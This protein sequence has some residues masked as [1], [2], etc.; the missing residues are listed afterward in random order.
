MTIQALLAARAHKVGRA[1]PS[2]L[3][4]HRALSVDPLCIVAW[5]L[6]SEPYS[7][8]AIAIGTK[9]SGFQL[10]V[11]GYPLDRH[12][13]FASL[14]DFAR[15]FC[16]AFEAF[17]RGPTESVEHMGERLL[18]PQRLP[19]IVVANAETIALLGRLGR[20]LA[21]LPVDG[22]DAADP[23]LPR[24]GRHLMWLIEHAQLPGQQIIVSLAD[25]LAQHY[26]TA[27]SLLEMQSLAAADAWI[28]P[29]AGIHGFHAAEVA[30]TAAVGPV[31]RP[32]DARE[33]YALM[34]TLNEQRRGSKDPAH[35]SQL[36]QPLR[37]LYE[38]M[39]QQSW[40]LIWRVLDRECAKPEAPSVARR[41]REDRIE[42]ASHLIW[43]NGAAQ[44]RR[45]TR[46]TPRS[47]AMHLNRMEV[48][49][50]LLLAEEAIDDPLRMAPHLLAGRAT[51]G[52]VTRVDA[53]RRE[54]VNSRNCR[55]P[56]VT[57]RTNEPCMIP[58]GADLWWTR[59]PQGREWRVD[60][61]SPRADGGSDVTLVLQTNRMPGPGLPAR[62]TRVCF[63]EFNTL[64]PYQLFLPTTVP[65]THKAAETESDDLEA[66][67]DSGGRA[68]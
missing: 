55:R 12:L 50:A 45:K 40:N 27:T 67:G 32:E 63:S 5:Q 8:G 57:L 42:Y 6:G 62:G 46:M 41:A 4:R 2:A 61:V 65:W 33:V 7:V 66:S 39:V 52:V 53:D 38:R 16:A 29:P 21:Y 60:R 25:L 19:Q 51:A 14:L 44:G 47:A 34:T 31:L 68:A 17:A 24:L 1:Q 10:F 26:V 64:Q 54:L 22:E 11:P 49:N 3:M 13:L 48:A 59:T 58:T 18:I 15:V 30:E 35:V 20:R 37:R 23:L 28:A 43:M 36:A 56:A 9:R